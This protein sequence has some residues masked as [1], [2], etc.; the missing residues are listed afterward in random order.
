[1]ANFIIVESGRCLLGYS[2]ATDLGI[3]RVDPTGTLGTADCN[4]VDD[5]FVGEL[6]A[7]YSS[8]FKGIGKLKD[9]QLKLHDDPNVTPVV[10]KMRRVPFSVK[11]KVTAKVN[12]LLDK[13]IIEKVKGPTV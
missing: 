6:K 9:Y 13:D 2:T 5:T 3:V 12:E 1:L 4:A 10:Q 11:D 8:V 7:K